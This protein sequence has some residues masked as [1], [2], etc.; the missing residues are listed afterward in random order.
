VWATFAVVM[1]TV[2]PLVMGYV[3]EEVSQRAAVG[4]CAALALAL[5]VVATASR[6]VREAPSID[7]L[8]AATAVPE[9]AA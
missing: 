5:A 6:A 2:A 8:A 1:A 7:E 3:I 4:I 9:S